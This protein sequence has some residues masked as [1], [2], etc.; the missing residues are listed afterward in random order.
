MAGRPVSGDRPTPP[1]RDHPDFEL[2]C[3]ERL[4]PEYQALAERLA[5]AGWDGMDIA[6]AMIALAE[7][8]ARTI[9][10]NEE[11]EAAIRRA[12]KI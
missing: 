7:A 2:L 9:E 10:A 4:E 6:L 11:T 1:P 8:H 12:K 5:A 3:Q